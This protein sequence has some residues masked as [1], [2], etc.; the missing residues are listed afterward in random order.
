MDAEESAT[1]SRED[2]KALILEATGKDAPPGGIPDD[3]PLFGGGT[4]LELDSLDGL[5]I[6]MA[7]QRRWGIRVNDPKEL[8]RVLE[9]V[10]TLE[11]F[12]REQL[13]ASS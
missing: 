4:P 12:I 1:P 10:A 5:Q 13:R 3:Q 9:S 6:S 2:L 8:R 7:L 11:A